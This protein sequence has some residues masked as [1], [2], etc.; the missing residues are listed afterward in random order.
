MT[1]ILAAE[2]GANAERLGELVDFLFHL[3]IAEGVAALRAF[4]R[5]VIKVA[6]RSK[7]DGFQR[8]LGGET[9]DDDRQM[10]GRTGCRSQSQDLFLEEVDHPVVGQK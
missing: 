6:G 2:L 10:V 5:Q 9:A 1:E 4:G 7:L 3:Q 8:H